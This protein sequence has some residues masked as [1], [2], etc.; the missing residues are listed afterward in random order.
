[1][2]LPA[3]A[4]QPLASA[5]RTAWRR[6][7][8][9][10]QRERRRIDT[11]RRRMGSSMRQHVDA[12]GSMNRPTANAASSEPWPSWRGHPREWGAFAAAPPHWPL[13]QMTSSMRRLTGRP[14]GRPFAQRCRGRAWGYV[15]A[16]AHEWL[17]SCASAG[18]GR[19]PC[20]RC[21]QPSRC[22][23]PPCRQPR[24]CPP[25]RQRQGS[26]PPRSLADA[27]R[28]YHGCHSPC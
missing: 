28:V 19:S 23:S 6:R 15:R 18:C 25:R 2:Q 8:S 11:A 26:G 20:A 9:F 1:M 7:Q 10:G 17:R 5:R 3:S 14:R 27:A 24:R 22:D 13:T 21:H 4:A 12:C 16:L